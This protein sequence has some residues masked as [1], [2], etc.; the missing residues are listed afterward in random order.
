MKKEII[1]VFLILMGFQSVASQDNIVIPDSL[2][3]RDYEYLLEKIITIDEN[4]SPLPNLYAKTYVN[5]G[6]LT[7]DTLRMVQGYYLLSQVNKHKKAIKYADSSI[8]LCKGKK[9]DT[10]PFKQYRFKAGLHYDLGQYKEA[11]DAYIKAKKSIDETISYIDISHLNYSMALIYTMSNHHEASLPIYKQSLN[12]VRD[13]NLQDSHSDSYLTSLDALSIAYRHVKNIDSSK[14]LAKECYENAIIY[15]NNYFL[16]KSK[17][18]LGILD[19][20]EGNYKKAYDT[21]IKYSS[22]LENSNETIDLSITYFF[23]GKSLAKINQWDKAISFLKKTDSLIIQYEYTI[24]E[25]LENYELLY[26]HFKSEMDSENQ[27]IYL[28]KLL[29]YDSLITSSVSGINNKILNNSVLTRYDT[30]V[31]LKEKELLIENLEAINT[32]KTKLSYSLTILVV[33]LAIFSFYSFRK[34]KVYKKRFE[35]LVAKETETPPKKNKPTVSDETV[36]KV[37]GKL[38]KY[39]LNKGFLDP[40]TSLEQLAKILDTNS[41]YL[42]RI[43]NKYKSKNFS[44]YISDLRIDHAISEIQEK[45][46]L[47]NYT[48]KA[49]SAE[50]GFKN[51]ESFTKAF[52]KKTGIYPSYYIKKLI[53]K[54]N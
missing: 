40:N 30:P 51:S 52:Y 32:A 21:I 10:Y 27:L 42:S 18:N 28:E 17:V 22:Y 24:P 20:Y 41:N 12:Y 29:R 6:I 9:Y 33:L 4:I 26:S 8:A 35:K 37:L 31:L 34:R 11:L 3:D 14:I 47:Q 16:N 19:F 54:N 39:E 7:K 53:K 43:V 50:F 5:K 1:V 36:K 2:K 13:N 23:A 15:N 49:I 45:K 38:E 48:I 44:T 46:I 25:L